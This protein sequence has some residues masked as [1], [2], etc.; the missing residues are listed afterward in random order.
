M[1]LVECVVVLLWGNRGNDE[2]MKLNCAL[3]NQET[4]GRLE[5]LPKPG[6]GTSRHIT[7]DTG[8][9]LFGTFSILSSTTHLSQF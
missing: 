7:T 8:E 4:E 6:P 9:I 5:L 2:I 1:S 3:R